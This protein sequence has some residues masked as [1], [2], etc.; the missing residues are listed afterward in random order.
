MSLTIT[1]IKDKLSQVSAQDFP[2]LR[3][4]LIADTRKGV[5]SAIAACEKRLERERAEELRLNGMYDFQNSISLGNL[6]VGIDEVGRGPLAGPLC[7]AGVVL[8]M[9]PVITGLNDSKKISAGVR[10]EIA[11]E[12]RRIALAFYIAEVDATTIDKQ[13]MSASLRYAFAEVVRN[14]DSALE[15]VRSVII[16]GN[17]LG[18]DPR[19]VNVVKGDAKVACIAAASIIAKVHRDNLMIAYSKEFPEYD[20]ASSKGYGSARHI[21]AIKDNGLCPIHRKSFCTSLTQ[22]TLF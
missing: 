16:D 13:G 4:S 12:I 19:E 11:K 10:E 22:E 9:S 1:Q 7:V 2:V 21:Q 17:A 3:K 14:I 8:P 15:D 5:I 6:C 18:I 20:F